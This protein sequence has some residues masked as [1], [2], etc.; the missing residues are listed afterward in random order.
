MWTSSPQHTLAEMFGWIAAQATSQT[1]RGL[2][3]LG[4]GRGIVVVW[5]CG[6]VGILAGRVRGSSD[7]CCVGE[8]V[9]G[10]LRCRQ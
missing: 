9:V 4:Y 7:C 5:F 2:Q 3:S 8:E 6:V 10:L 1:H